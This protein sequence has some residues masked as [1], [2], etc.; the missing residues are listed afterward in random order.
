MRN[1]DVTTCPFQCRASSNGDQ[2]KWRIV[3]DTE[4]IFVKE[5]LFLKHYWKDN[6][7]EKIASEICRQLHIDWLRYAS[8]ELCSIYDGNSITE[9]CY[10][11]NFLKPDEDL[12]SMYNLMGAA[13]I[14]LEYS[15]GVPAIYIKLL[16]TMTQFGIE[17]AADYLSVMFLVDFLVCNTDRHLS[18]ITVLRNKSGYTI[19]PLFDFGQGLSQGSYA[20]T[21]M[22]VKELIDTL[23][24]KPYMSSFKSVLKF[25]LGQGAIRS[26]IPESLDVT[27]LQF[28]SFSSAVVLGLQCQALGIKLKGVE[29]P[30]N[31]D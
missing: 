1:F 8:Y 5:Q 31:Y 15:D 3:T 27:G 19:A 20:N 4:D 26:Y 11:S 28:P 10:S 12:I 18:N 6:L 17:K 14:A 16:N 25:F 7:V 30:S 2:R 21:I 13:D 22:P 23:V 9:G 24:Y 29:K